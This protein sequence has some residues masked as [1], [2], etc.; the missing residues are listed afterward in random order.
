MYISRWAPCRQ[1]DC[2]YL[3]IVR[4]ILLY[5][6]PD[7]SLLV[8]YSFEVF[9]SPKSSRLED[10]FGQIDEIDVSSA[11]AVKMM[12]NSWRTAAR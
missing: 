12:R 10:D 2:P 6:L 1:V 9:C 7:I 4:F 8:G 11:A 5:E 3:A